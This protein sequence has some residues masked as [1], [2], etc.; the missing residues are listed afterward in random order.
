MKINWNVRDVRKK[1]VC[2]KTSKAYVSHSECDGCVFLY[3][4]LGRTVHDDVVECNAPGDPLK[5]DVVRVFNTFRT[6]INQHK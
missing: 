4:S 6:H 1:A 3:A 2:K 5:G